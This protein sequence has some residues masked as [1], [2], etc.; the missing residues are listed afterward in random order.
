MRLSQLIEDY[1]DAIAEA[2]GHKA[3]RRALERARAYKAAYPHGGKP[4]HGESGAVKKDIPPEER[5]AEKGGSGYDPTHSHS[6]PGSFGA[7]GWHSHAK[8]QDP[9]HV[10][11]QMGLIKKQPKRVTP[12]P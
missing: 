7:E 5:W 11:T 8:K 12:L 9:K 3:I 6:E 4:K 1:A 2:K 10:K